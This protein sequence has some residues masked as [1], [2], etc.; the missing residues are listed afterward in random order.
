[1]VELTDNHLLASEPLKTALQAVPGI[2][3]VQYLNELDEL[4]QVQYTP[5][6]FYLYFGD[7][8]SDK[9]NAGASMQLKQTWLVVLVDRLGCEQSTGKLLT[10]TIRAL[11]G[12]KTDMV[13]PWQ[14]VNTPIKPRY[15][16]G[17]G[18]FPLAFTS[19][20]KMRGN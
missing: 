17:Y 4:D 19:Q 16:K 18:F 9:A 14:R 1:M 11:A 3:H 12:K 20:F 13:G 10:S 2:R 15:T 7:D 5:T 6:L 8:I